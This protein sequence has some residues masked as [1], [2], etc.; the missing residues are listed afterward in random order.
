ME[1]S[2]PI[3]GAPPVGPSTVQSANGDCPT[4]G[5]TVFWVR[6]QTSGAD[7]SGW[8]APLDSA[9]A[10]VLVLDPD[11]VYVSVSSSGAAAAITPQR[12]RLHRCPEEAV[13][14][15]LARVGSLGFYTASVL[16]VSC[17]LGGCG[18]APGQ[19]CLDNRRDALTRPHGA[20]RSL[21]AEF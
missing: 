10:G 21:S 12:H 4:C 5:S 9:Q 1:S 7:G 13:R 20:R 14:E 15:V 11:L 18:A 16:S 17:P 19:L 8:H 6:D 2:R 3:P